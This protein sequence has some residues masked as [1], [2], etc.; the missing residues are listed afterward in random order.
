MQVR[1]SAMVVATCICSGKSVHYLTPRNGAFNLYDYWEMEMKE[2]NL[3]F[4]RKELLSALHHAVFVWP[5]ITTH[6]YT[7]ELQ[8]YVGWQWVI[9]NNELLLKCDARLVRAIGK[10]TY[11]DYCVSQKPPEQVAQRFKVQE[12]IKGE[13][14]YEHFKGVNAKVDVSLVDGKVMGDM[15]MVMEDESS[16]LTTFSSENRALLIKHLASAPDFIWP[17]NDAQAKP[18]MGWGAWWWEWYTIDGKNQLLLVHASDLNEDHRISEHDW[19]TAARPIY[20]EP[21]LA[22]IELPDI[23]NL[24]PFIMPVVNWIPGTKPTIG[25]QCGQGTI[26]HVG[27]KQICVDIGAD[28]G[29]AIVHLTQIDPVPDEAYCIANRYLSSTNGLKGE[30]NKGKVQ[31]LADALRMMQSL[32]D[33]TLN[34]EHD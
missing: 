23:D 28:A 10:A 25:Q 7:N 12:A 29:L 34:N 21:P 22:P 3:A 2:S 16:R 31:R 18:I 1:T 5:E 13:P 11:V 30:V 8:A 4:T 33:L 32:G 6:L 9:A 17:I 14:E 20:A 19:V 24:E 15:S 26:M 27:C